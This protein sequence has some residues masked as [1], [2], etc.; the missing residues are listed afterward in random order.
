MGHHRIY[1]SGEC[2]RIHALHHTNQ[3]GAHFA[4]EPLGQ[5]RVN[6]LA[7]ERSRLGVA[8]A[9]NA[10]GYGRLLAPADGVLIDVITP[11]AP[12]AEFMAQ[13]ATE[14]LPG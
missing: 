3:P 1:E 9:R 11:I 13:Y 5:A 4:R 10:L 12:S 6:R 2:D 7:V 14:A 8:Q